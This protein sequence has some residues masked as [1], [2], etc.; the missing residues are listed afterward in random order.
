MA[1]AQA[2]APP[3]P[4]SAAPLPAQTAAVVDL[5][6]NSW[7]LVAYR[8]QPGGWWRRIGQL[9]EPVRIAEGLARSGRLSEPAMDRGL[10]TLEVFARYCDARGIAPERVE[11]VAT[12]AIRDARNGRDLVRRAG[13][14]SGLD[15]RILSAAEEARYGYL[16]AVNSTTLTDGAVLDLGGGSL[17]LVSV[18]D[19]EADAAGSWP[20]GAVRVTES[21]LNR[22]GPASRKDLKKARAAIRFALA[23]AA[24]VSDHGR[25][26]VGIGGAVRNLAAAAQRAHGSM[27]EPLQGFVLDAGALS[28]LI[29]ALA[30]RAAA[31]RALAGIKPARAPFILA[32]ALV[33]EGVLERGGFAGIEVTRAGL[34]EGVFLERR[35]LADAAPLLPDVRGAAVRDLAA[36]SGAD[37]RHAD[38]VARLALQLHDSL[39]AGGVFAPEADERDLLRSAA[40]LH[41][42]GMAVA[43]G[44]HHEHAAYAIRSSGLD[45]FGPREIGLV[46]DIV[47]RHRKGPTDGDGGLVRR[48]ATLLQIAEQLERGE[49]GSV[50][51]ASLEQEGR[52]V[53]LELVGDDTLARWSVARNVDA[54][55][56]RRVFG[57][58]L[59]LP[60]AA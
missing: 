44:G 56:F 31:G 59:V 1:L 41:D 54:S 19:R 52:A 13:D 15:V 33:L 24:W 28:A 17:Q 45:G 50:Q 29:A 43:Y 4:G 7:R 6:S 55:G 51:A 16:A 57:R 2:D 32:A 38:H 37:L 8:Y 42:I 22:R 27:G 48:C 10:A 30:K 23:D 40:I 49:D 53:R 60:A 20:L 58:R 3:T 36:R 18:R 11:A 39:A 47:R 9:Q 14:M 25:R 21:L 26:L 34:R 5:G 46:A 12:S 35:L